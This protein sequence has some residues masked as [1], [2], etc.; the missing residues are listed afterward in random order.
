[1]NSNDLM[2]AL[3]GLD[4]KYIDEAAFELKDTPVKKDKVKAFRLKKALYIALPAA[5]VAFLTITVTL[6]FIMR[7]GS[8][9][10]ASSP[11]S[12]QAYDAADTAE[13]Y[14][15]EEAAA[16]EPAPAYEAEE[17]AAWTVGRKENGET[18]TIRNLYGDG[19]KTTEFGVFFHQRHTIYLWKKGAH[20]SIMGV[21]RKPDIW[22]QYGGKSDGEEKPRLGKLK[23][24]LCQDRLQVRGQL[25]GGCWQ[26][27]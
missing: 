10:Q 3:S 4:P 16:E 7:L 8:S 9:D 21:K 14:D 17:A 19:G 13:A 6:P 11:A 1:M 26:V 5:A 27:G 25:H 22:R 12:D 2:N 23:F 24:F 15:A 20:G 18:V